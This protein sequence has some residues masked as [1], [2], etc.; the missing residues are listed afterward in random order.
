MPA[1][2]QERRLTLLLEFTRWRFTVDREDGTDIG[3]LSIVAHATGPVERPAPDPNVKTKEMLLFDTVN[4]A[5]PL[6]LERLRGR[7]ATRRRIKLNM[8]MLWLKSDHT[9]QHQICTARPSRHC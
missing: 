2:P 9:A 1:A 7:L 6:A 8:L 5:G 3:P 4:D